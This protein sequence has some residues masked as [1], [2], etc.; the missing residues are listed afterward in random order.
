MGGWNYEYETPLAPAAPA[1]VGRTPAFETAGGHAEASRQATM[2]GETEAVLRT[3]FQL[4]NAIRM[5][6]MVRPALPDPDAATSTRAPPSP[7]ATAFESNAGLPAILAMQRDLRGATNERAQRRMLA[8]TGPTEA[9]DG[10]PA[11]SITPALSG[12][13][14]SAPPPIDMDRQ[15]NERTQDIRA[16]QMANHE[17]LGS[18]RAVLRQQVAAARIAQALRQYADTAPVVRNRDAE[19]PICIE[20][21][22]A[23]DI[24]VRLTCTHFMHKECLEQWEVTLVRQG[25]DNDYKCPLCRGDPV[26]IE[27][28]NWEQLET[29][30]P[31]APAA[32]AEDRPSSHGSQYSSATSILTPRENT[33]PWWPGEESIFLADTQLPGR[34]SWIVDIGAW[35]NLIGLN[36]AL[37]Q[38]QAAK[39]AGFAVREDKRP[40]PLRVAGVG[41]GQQTAEWD[42]VCPLA[43]TDETGV[44]DIHE[45]RAPIVQGDGA[46]L[47]G[48]LGLSSLER[49]GA[50]IDTRRRQLILP[51]EGEVQVQ[52]PPGSTVLPMSKAPSGH[53]VLPTDAYDK[54]RTG[55]GGLPPRR[56]VLLATDRD[57]PFRPVPDPPAEPGPNP[58]MKK[59]YFDSDD[60]ETPVCAIDLRRGA[61]CSGK[62]RSSGSGATFPLPSQ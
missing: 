21:Y 44:T 38:T 22:E 41:R 23:G 24:L 56:M 11:W 52:L 37:K 31:P 61:G 27:R 7:I 16:F 32:A 49:N 19:C 28:G 1:A 13:A 36:L 15:A 4:V 55:R 48:L 47:P 60:E 43:L 53:L 62:S 8:N 57:E 12:S 9:A 59:I 58:K 10:Q 34:I 6:G 2:L 25:R 54:V 3:R 20:P 40:E 26:I 35:S 45:I 50:I 51:G 39:S 29:S 14:F 18:E 30:P 5:E 42:M 33:F 46:N 17:V